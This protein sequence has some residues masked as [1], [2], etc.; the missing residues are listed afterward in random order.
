[1]REEARPHDDG[2]DVASFA[3]GGLEEPG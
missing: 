1:V 2:D 3:C